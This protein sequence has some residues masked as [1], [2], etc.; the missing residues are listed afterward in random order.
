MKRLQGK[1]FYE[2]KSKLKLVDYQASLNGN[3]RANLA[4]KTSMSNKATYYHWLSD[5]EKNKFLKSDYFK[6]IK[7]IDDQIKSLKGEK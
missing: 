3:I 6:V 5:I 1:D 7:E 2:L 4:L